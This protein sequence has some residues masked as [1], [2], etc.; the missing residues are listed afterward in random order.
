[1]KKIIAIFTV[2][3]VAA[4]ALLY[5]AVAAGLIAGGWFLAGPIGLG[6][7]VVLVALFVLGLVV[8]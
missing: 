6:V 4:F 8:A 2:L 1:M 3:V 5:L 7:A